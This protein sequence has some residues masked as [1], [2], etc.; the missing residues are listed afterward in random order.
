M[1]EVSSVTAS[2]AVRGIATRLFCVGV[3][4]LQL[5]A[6][7]ASQNAVINRSFRLLNIDLDKPDIGGS[8]SLVNVALIMTSKMMM[9]MMMMMSVIT[10]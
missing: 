3:Y 1:F 7:G 8:A 4:L 10:G 5:A 6:C 9:V 2:C